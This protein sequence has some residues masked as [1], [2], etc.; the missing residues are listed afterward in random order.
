[1]T[2]GT[3]NRIIYGQATDREGYGN[4]NGES[5]QQSDN[6]NPGQAQDNGNRVVMGA[7]HTGRLNIAA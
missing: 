5:R 7:P 3:Q 2:I 1:M 4:A 6:R